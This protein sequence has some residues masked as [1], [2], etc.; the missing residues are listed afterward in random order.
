[1]TVATDYGS[2]MFSEDCGGD[3]GSDGLSELISGCLKT[4]LSDLGGFLDRDSICIFSLS[5]LYRL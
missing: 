5:F 3:C 2:C 1:M 4:R